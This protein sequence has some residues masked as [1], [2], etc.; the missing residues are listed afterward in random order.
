MDT[1]NS[2]PA[3]ISLELEKLPDDFGTGRLQ[4]LIVS[5]DNLSSEFPFT[6][7]ATVFPVKCESQFIITLLRGTVKLVVNLH[8]VELNAGQSLTMMPGCIF[9]GRSVSED[10]RFCGLLMDKEFSEAI[11]N[12]IGLK[13]DLTRRYYSFS[14]HNFTVAALESYKQGYILLRQELNRDDYTYKK[15]VVQR[16]CEIAV[17]KNLSLNELPKTLPELNKPLTRKEEI[18]HDFLTLLEKYYTQERSISY[19]ADRM[20]LT[21]KYLSTIIKEVSGKHG[22]QWI[23]EYVLLEA[24]ALLRN[25][26]LSVKQVSDKLNFPS[27]SMFGRFFKKM[28]GYSPKQYKLL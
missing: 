13:V 18:F 16:Y 1:P 28:T 26:T 5:F 11:R 7:Q 25:S 10:I 2:N 22:M 20:C 4:N 6:S 9:E 3:P 21:P 14:I 23:D 27:Q 19:Y 24:K 15:E 12:S 8:E 17:L